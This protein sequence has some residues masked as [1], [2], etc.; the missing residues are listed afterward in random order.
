M[1]ETAT[2]FAT[3]VQP[4][5]YPAS[6]KQY[7]EGSR[8]DIRVPYREIMLSPTK[9][10]DRVEQNAP[11]P[12]YDTSGP[13]TD[14]TTEVDLAQGLTPLR[15]AW[16]AER[17]DTERLGGVTSAYGRQRQNDLMAYGLRFPVRVKPLR[18]LPGKNVSQMHYARQGIITPEMEFIAL[19]E[20][21]KLDQLLSSPEYAL[22][23]RQHRG[24]SFGA[25]LPEQMTPEFVRSEVASGRAIIPANIN[26]PELEPMIIGRNF[27][28]SKST[29]TSATRR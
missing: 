13:F 6:S 2:T 12:V 1:T 15:K 14:P 27:R 16:I 11:L 21:L 20:S 7:I 9:H 29:A 24:H 8:P 25:M 19:R 17:N 23:R 10:G 22:L 5:T 18:A 28:A 4:Q 26:H 3:I